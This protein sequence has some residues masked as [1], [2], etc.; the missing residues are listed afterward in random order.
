MS[1]LTPE[2]ATAILHSLGAKDAQ[3]VGSMQAD[4]PALQRWLFLTAVWRCIVNDDGAWMNEW[5]DNSKA[6]VPRAI[7]RMLDAGADPADL[8]DVVRGMQIDLAF[9]LLNLLEQ[10][11]YGIEDM[12]A[13]IA[14]PCDW[15][16]CEYDQATQNAG[17]P[18]ADLHSDFYD[19]DPTGRRGEPR[20]RRVRKR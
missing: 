2:R 9:D 20:K 17:R 14:E 10:S 5:G 1:V 19:F 13:R 15:A 3:D 18:M 16:L 8:T 11:D 7:R 12:Q 4:E 6:P